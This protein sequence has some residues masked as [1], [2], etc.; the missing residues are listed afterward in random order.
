MNKHLLVI[1]SLLFSSSVLAVLNENDDEQG[2]KRTIIKDLRVSQNLPPYQSG[3]SSFRESSSIGISHT[4]F[5]PEAQEIARA[6]KLLVNP[7]KQDSLNIAICEDGRSAVV[8]PKSW[9]DIILNRVISGQEGYVRVM[10]PSELPYQFHGH[11]IIKFLNGKEY[12][13]SGTLV[14]PHH[15]LTAGHNIF[16]HKIGEGW[17]T[18][19]KFIPA[20]NEAEMLFGEAQGAVLLSVS[21]WVENQNKEYDFGM[22]IL[23]ESIG[24]RTG[25][26]GIF[27]APDNFLKQS[28]IHISGYPGNKVEKDRQL[29]QMWTMSHHVKTVL[30]DQITYE[31]DTYPEQS[32]S[33]VW[34]QLTDYSGYYV[35]GVHAYDEENQNDEN[36]ATRI[37]AVKF[38]RLVSWIQE[39]QLKDFYHPELPSAEK[40]IARAIYVNYKDEAKRGDVES[41]YQLA[42][43]YKEGR[44]VRK[45]HDKAFKWYKK[46]AK[47]GHKIARH[48]L[49][50]CYKNGIGT[51]EHVASALGLLLILGEENDAWVQNQIG[52]V[53]KNGHDVPQ[54]YAEAL[55]WYLKA[56]AQG[57]APA[58]NNIGGLYKKGQGVVVDY[59][60]A[61][62]WYQLAAAQNHAAA[63]NNIGLLYKKGLGVL[64]DYDEAM[65]WFRL[66][67]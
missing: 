52:G 4:D 62:R 47:Q 28:I 60:E 14:G 64:Q 5:Y 15:I 51:E 54:D 61:M 10:N 1:F 53:Y 18:S 6:Q 37:S 22:V 45:N 26:A 66:A 35:V 63:Q 59:A 58:Q 39:Y 67:A 50:L 20:R 31:I 3:E 33:G 2:L 48:E 49:V 11:M 9:E 38:K 44:G 16:S 32:G 43:C 46:A 25:W 56:A 41:Q 27:A 29:A 19:V 7:Y 24:Y 23:D 13:G 21:N 30:K 65:R 36:A 42:T 55:S 34:T 40:K 12:V 8:E 17:A 57:Y